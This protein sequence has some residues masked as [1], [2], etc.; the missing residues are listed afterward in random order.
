MHLQHPVAHDDLD[1][2]G[3]QV[4]WERMGLAGLEG[5]KITILNLQL[6]VVTYPNL[7]AARGDE[8][9]LAEFQDKEFDLVFSNSVI[10]HLCSYVNQ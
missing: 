9:Y 4:F 2:G 3:E 10:E 1:L 6:P 7:H 5:H 8:V